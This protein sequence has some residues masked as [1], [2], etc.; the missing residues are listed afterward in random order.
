VLPV[1]DLIEVAISE[2]REVNVVCVAIY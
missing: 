2:K 1:F